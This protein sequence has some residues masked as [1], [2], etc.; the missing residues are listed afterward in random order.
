MKPTERPIAREGA[1]QKNLVNVHMQ[2]FQVRLYYEIEMQF[3]D[4]KHPAQLLIHQCFKVAFMKHYQQYVAKA[5]PFTTNSD[6]L[7]KIIEKTVGLQS[8]Y[9]FKM[10]DQFEKVGDQ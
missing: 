2:D 8:E 5:T 1:G 6:L 10:A 4:P 7:N 9:V 3:S